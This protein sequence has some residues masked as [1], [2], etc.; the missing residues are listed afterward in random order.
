MSNVKR[1]IDQR[2]VFKNSSSACPA[3]IIKLDI[4][5]ELSKIDNPAS[6]KEVAG[7]ETL[8]VI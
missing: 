6:K 8:H 2:F 3:F 1:C 7:C 5:P 4:Q